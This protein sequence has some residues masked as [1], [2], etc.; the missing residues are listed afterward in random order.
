MLGSATWRISV[1]SIARR[2]HF[3]L[4]LLLKFIL[5]GKNMHIFKHFHTITK[6]RHIV[7][8]YCFK[9]GIGV[10]GLR[11]DLSK[12]SPTEFFNGAKYYQ[13]TRSPND[14]ERE[15]KCLP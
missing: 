1:L 4:C 14:R 7:M 6:N 13:G 9:L 2:N 15:V 8:H 3:F 10:Q 5:G 12:Y 11:H